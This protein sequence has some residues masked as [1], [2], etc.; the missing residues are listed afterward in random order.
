MKPS[1]AKSMLG[2]CLLLPLTSCI[3]STTLLT[4]RP[5]GSGTIEQTTTMNPQV[6]SQMAQM[7]SAFGAKEAGS[8]GQPPD[9]FSEAE[10]KAAAAK[11]GEG[12]RLVSAT[13]IK[14]ADAEGLKAVY[15][16]DDIN[17]IRVSQKPSGPAGASGAPGMSI[18]GSQ[19]EEVSFR[20]ARQPGGNSVLSI[21]FPESPKLDA[22]DQE[23]RETPTPDSMPPQAMEMMKQMFKGLRIDMAVNVDG[24]IVKTN[25]PFQ[26]GSKVT[27]MLIDF[28]TLLA[29]EALLTK[30][31]RP[32]S[33]EAAKAVLKD[34][35]G[36]K[37]NLER[38]V[39]VE[40]AP[41]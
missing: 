3:A 12:V 37:I 23:P 10:A 14:T 41:R 20:L 21:R 2:L 5:D 19:P 39:T 15:A 13:R 32:D 34:L 7:M 36:V 38:E 11:M 18:G 40:F 1:L 27:L 29:N 24:R 17:R 6:I 35:P 22:P 4:I 31:Q 25:S 8:A 28:E 26:E 16:F 30:L 9:I 33:L